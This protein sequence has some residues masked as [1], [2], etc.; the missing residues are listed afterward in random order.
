M[1]TK[2]LRTYRSEQEAEASGCP[3]TA[4]HMRIYS[5][6]ARTM[7]EQIEAEM[8]RGMPGH[9]ATGVAIGAA[10]NVMINAAVI[11]AN[12]DQRTILAN[13]IYVHERVQTFARQAELEYLPARG[14]A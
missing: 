1:S 5:A 12:G 8:R 14:G 6:L 10:A 2:V 9:G 7:R 13:L 11:I 4:A 3:Y